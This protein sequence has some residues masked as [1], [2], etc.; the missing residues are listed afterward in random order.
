MLT[1]LKHIKG[2]CKERELWCPNI[3]QT[4]MNFLFVKYPAYCFTQLIL[5]IY[6]TLKF[7]WCL[8][9]GSAND[10]KKNQIMLILWQ[11]SLWLYIYSRMGLYWICHILCLYAYPAF[12]PMCAH[13]Y[14]QPLSPIP[15]WAFPSYLQCQ[16][17][18]S[19]IACQIPD[20]IVLLSEE[21]WQ[22]II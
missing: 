21:W 13:D 7:R 6:C 17:H 5:W 3:L 11:L 1:W 4:I 8:I 20:L 22:L 9:I 10:W 18:I 14:F 12:S 15:A 19:P 2:G 16:L